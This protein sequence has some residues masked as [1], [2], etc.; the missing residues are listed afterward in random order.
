M[1]PP[2]IPPRILLDIRDYWP[3]PRSSFG[4][5]HLGL[6]RNLFVNFQ[7][8]L[9][10]HLALILYMRHSARTVLYLAAICRLAESDTARLPSSMADDDPCKLQCC[11]RNL[12]DTNN[13]L[14]TE[15]GVCSEL[16]ISLADIF[17]TTTSNLPA[18]HPQ[19]YSNTELL[20]QAALDG[21]TETVRRLFT[22]GAELASYRHQV[23]SVDEE[24]N[25]F[26]MLYAHT[27]YEVS[28]IRCRIPSESC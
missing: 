26:H 5:E 11:N 22:A 19:S 24:P 4:L 20:L 2:R 1:P 17:V 25:E 13:L 23:K 28:N 21:N 14:H 6:S 8:V 27:D 10:N 18:T 15:R 16:P 9:S 12:D 3:T 7:Q